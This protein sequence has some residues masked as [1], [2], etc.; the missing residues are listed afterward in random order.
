[1]QKKSDL[2]TKNDLKKLEKR[3][4]KKFESMDKKFGSIDK[5]MDIKFLGFKGEIYDLIEDK[6][7]EN[8]IER[9]QFHSKI[10]SAVD[11]VMGEMKAMREENIILNSRSQENR[12]KLSDHEERIFGLE[13]VASV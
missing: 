11:A 5:K 9:T 12:E 3:M 13:Q 7:E 1:M 4:D 6:F 10:L 2:V 8:R